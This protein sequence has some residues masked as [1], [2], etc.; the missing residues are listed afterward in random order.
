MYIATNIKLVDVHLT[1]FAPQTELP[2]A[3]SGYN[4]YIIIIATLL[5]FQVKT[6]YVASTSTAGTVLADDLW[7]GSVLGLP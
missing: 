1:D 7:G 5:R 4:L 3:A 2:S 6:Y